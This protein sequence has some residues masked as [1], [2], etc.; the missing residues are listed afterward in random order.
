[1]SNQNIIDLVSSLLESR[2]EDLNLWDIELVKEGPNLV[3]RVFIDKDGGVGISDC[4]RIS[5]F[6]SYELDLAD[7]IKNPYMLEVSSPGINRALKRDEDFIKY[8]GHMADVKLYKAFNK[9]KEYT[10][11]IKNYENNALTIEANKEIY[12]FNKKDIAS[13]RLAVIF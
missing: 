2:L 9:K 3:L 5:K 10:G 6:L 7:P 1:M 4:E 11:Q 13:C 8:I 12:H